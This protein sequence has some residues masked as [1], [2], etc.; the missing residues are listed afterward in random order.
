MT[1]HLLDLP[2]DFHI[3]FSPDKC[4]PLYLGQDAIL[5]K[6]TLDI[7]MLCMGLIFSSFFPPLLVPG[8][9]IGVGDELHCH[10]QK[11]HAFMQ[12]LAGI[13]GGCAPANSRIVE[14][15]FSFS[16]WLYLQFLYRILKDAFG[17]QPKVSLLPLMEVSHTHL[18]DSVR[19]PSLLG[20]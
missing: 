6:V 14:L 1:A 10:T 3:Q 7:Y 9:G 18:P 13:G 15:F 16:T 20:R 11:L 19:P 4:L 12:A 2:C 5:T 8:F 17:I